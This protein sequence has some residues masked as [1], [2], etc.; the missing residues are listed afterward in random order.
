MSDTYAWPK[1]TLE[2]DPSGMADAL[3]F[4]NRAVPDR[5]PRKDLGMGGE[6]RVEVFWS[7]MG[8]GGIGGWR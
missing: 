7:A 2:L 8:Q 3:P 1:G 6:C 5:Q 4:L